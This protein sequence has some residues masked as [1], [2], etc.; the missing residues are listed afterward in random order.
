MQINKKDRI[1]TIKQLIPT[2]SRSILDIGPGGLKNTIHEQ[3]FNDVEFE[4]MLVIDIHQPNILER[5]QK[6]IDDS[7]YTFINEDAFKYKFNKKYDTITIIHVI[8]HFEEKKAIKLLNKLKKICTGK[9]LLETPDQFEDG[10]QVVAEEENIHQE[11]L[12][13]AD[14]KFMNENGFTRI[15]SYQ[16]NHLYSNSFYS[17]EVK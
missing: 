7:R 5:K 4:E 13:L 17:W 12:F 10:A 16:Q 9:I 3:M 1:P 11:H 6:Y 2:K 14:E 8:E 15:F